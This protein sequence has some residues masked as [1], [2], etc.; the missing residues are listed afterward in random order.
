[1]HFAPTPG[2]ASEAGLP[3]EIS[4]PSL[5]PLPPPPNG[6]DE[7]DEEDEE[8]GDG[9]PSSSGGGRGGEEGGDGPPPGGDDSGGDGG[10]PP[11]PSLPPPPLD[12]QK[13]QIQSGAVFGG[14][15]QMPPPT[16]TD[17]VYILRLPPG[18]VWVT[19]VEIVVGTVTVIWSVKV[20]FV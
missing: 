16:I 2:H 10:P 18:A 17:L 4:T 20:F 6:S 3:F 12:V 1:M 5:P 7:G 15:H 9:L 14:L 11:P 13:G 19:I 8:G